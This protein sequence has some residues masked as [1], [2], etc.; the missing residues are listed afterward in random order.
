MFVVPGTCERFTNPC[1]V[2][3]EWAHRPAFDGFRLEESDRPATVSVHEERAGGVTTR[4]ICSAPGSGNVVR[5][6]G[7]TIVFIYG[8]GDAFGTGH[9]SLVVSPL[10]AATASASPSVVDPGGSS[11]LVVTATGGI[12]PYSYSWLGPGLSAQNIPAPVGTPSVTSTYEAMVTDSVGQSLGHKPGQDPGVGYVPAPAKVTVHVNSTLSVTANPPA[13]NAGDFSVLSAFGQ[14][15]TPPYA[16]SWSP[17][18]GLDS[19]SLPNPT[20]APQRTTTYTVTVTDAEG[21]T[22][23]GS[24]DVYVGPSVQPTASPAA[25]AAGQSS[26]LDANPVGG[27]GVFT[28]A[29]FPAAGLSDS[30]IR[31]PVASPATST[32][33]FVRVTDGHGLFQDGQVMVTVT[34]AGLASSFTFRRGALDPIARTIHWTFDASASTGAIVSYA[35]DLLGNDG[36]V[37][38]TVSGGPVLEI[39]VA[40][41]AQRGTM[42]LTVAAANGATASLTLNYR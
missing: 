6:G 24:V 10:L 14:G 22:L 39:D 2:D 17:P 33:Y 18:A 35:W 27:D 40:E 11:Q 36:T 38:H 25:I 37:V 42:T 5:A 3:G 12:P 13:I 41:S 15:G 26:Q 31:N 20:A 7:D 30:A 1:V 4:S 19:P 21:V 8:R 16:Y 28:Y 29:W 23:T 9:L 34:A 32:E